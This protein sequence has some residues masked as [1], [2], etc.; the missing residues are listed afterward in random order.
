MI[1]HGVPKQEQAPP[2]FWQRLCRQAVLGVAGALGATAVAWLNA[3]LESH[4]S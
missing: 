1:E 2:P 3:W 4:K